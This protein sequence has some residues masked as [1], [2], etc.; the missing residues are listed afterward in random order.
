MKSKNPKGDRGG[1]AGSGLGSEVAGLNDAI[2]FPRRQI[3]KK[4]NYAQALDIYKIETIFT[5]PIDTGNP[6]VL[7]S[8][9]SF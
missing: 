4:N 6:C 7:K 8:T 3:I 1:S 2:K 9:K 5:N